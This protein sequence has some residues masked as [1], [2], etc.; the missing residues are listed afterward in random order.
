MY[1]ATQFTLL[2][3]KVVNKIQISYEAG[4]ENTFWPSGQQ[5]FWDALAKGFILRLYQI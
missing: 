4:W 2:H 1:E 5:C 3:P